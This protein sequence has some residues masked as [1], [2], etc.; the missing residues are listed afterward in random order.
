[1]GINSQMKAAEVMYVLPPTDPYEIE[2]QLELNRR[3]NLK[4]LR[5][6]LVRPVNLSPETHGS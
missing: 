5:F 2:A 4:P 1:M 3:S 6:A